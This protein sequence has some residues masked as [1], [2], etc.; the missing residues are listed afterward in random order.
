VLARVAC[1]RDEVPAEILFGGEGIVGAA[2]E[3]EVVQAMLAT[4][5]EGYQ[6]MELEVR[7]LSAA[8]TRVT[9]ERAAALVALEDGTTERGG[10]LSAALASLARALGS[11]LEL[12]A[13]FEIIARLGRVARGELSVRGRLCDR[14]CGGEGSCLVSH[15]LARPVCC[16]VLLPLELGDQSA[17][18][19]EVQL[20]RSTRGAV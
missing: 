5:C 9:A 15:A 12:G 7:S 8:L 1:Q 11:V 16:C 10:H 14:W 2:A 13:R 6:V 3:S 4:S 17:H 20:A 18:G 19:A